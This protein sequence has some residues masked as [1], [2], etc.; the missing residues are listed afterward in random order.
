MED[1]IYAIKVLN[2]AMIRKR[3]E[4]S[5]NYMVLMYSFY[6]IFVILHHLSLEKWFLGKES[7][8]LSATIKKMQGNVFLKNQRPHA[9][10]L[11]E[12]KHYLIIIYFTCKMSVGFDHEI[13]YK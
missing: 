5:L 10:D 11:E 8:D 13:L 4:V 12:K 9:A 2:K 3:K 6:I 7:C 1:K